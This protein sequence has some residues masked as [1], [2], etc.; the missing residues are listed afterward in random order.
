MAGGTV[1]LAQIDLN[2]LVSARTLL[3]DLGEEAAYFDD[4][5]TIDPPLSLTFGLQM[6][7]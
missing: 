7:F 5:L 4:L 1:N 3:R 6:R 2:L